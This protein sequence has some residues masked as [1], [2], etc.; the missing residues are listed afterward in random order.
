MPYPKKN[1][2]KTDFIK[3]FMGSSEANEDYP[4]RDQRFAVANSIWKEKKK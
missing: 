2:K 1:E 4:K 3:R